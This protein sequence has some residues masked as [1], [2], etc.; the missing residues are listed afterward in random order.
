M[1]RRCQMDMKKSETISSASS[2]DFTME[3]AKAVRLSCI[4]MKSFLYDFSQL[5]NAISFSRSCICALVITIVS[6]VK[7]V[8]F[9]QPKNQLLN[10]RLIL[11]RHLS[12]PIS[13]SSFSTSFV[14]FLIQKTSLKPLDSC[15]NNQHSIFWSS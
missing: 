7:L 12:F 9:N 5:C 13:C 10:L 3:Q 2:D 6:P 8:F 4:S 15:V 1:A 14:F 11:Y